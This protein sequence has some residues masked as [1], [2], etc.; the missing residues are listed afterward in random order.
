MSSVDNSTKSILARACDPVM[1]QQ[2]AAAI[3]AQI[4]NPEYVVTT[5]DLDF[6]EKLHSRQWSV[7]FFAPGACRF[8][9][10]GQSIP[11]GNDETRGWT[12]DE[13]RDL[14]RRTQGEQ[15]EIV[16]TLH[17]SETLERLNAALS[18]ARAN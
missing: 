18:I 10:A 8:S 14:V 6:V 11:G 1:A 5:S 7:V 16:E 13:Y 12:L 9:A 17:E 4:G 15:V 2:A 3:P